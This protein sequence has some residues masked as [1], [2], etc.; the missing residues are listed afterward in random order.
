[1]MLEE[2]FRRDRIVI[3]A[4]LRKA[5]ATE[6]GVPRRLAQAMGYALL[7]GGKR[8]RPFLALEG[9]RAAGGR[10]SGRVLRFC[11][12]LEMVHAFSLVHDDLPSMDNA[13]VRRGRASLHRRFDEATAILAADALLARGFGLMAESPGPR[14]RVCRVISLVA[15][16]IGAAG[17][18][19]GQWEDMRP[20]RMTLARLAAVQR[21]KTGELIAASL[22]GGAI[23]AGA[24]HDVERALWQAGLAVGA[25]FQMTDDLLD[26]AE[27]GERKGSTMVG[28]LGRERTLRRARAAAGRAR[29]LLTGLG[30]RF[31]LLAEVP[32][33]VLERKD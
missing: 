23:L 24:G 7:G 17:M 11:C 3:D 8:I 16:A 4:A 32:G 27:G 31:A 28:R 9:F 30:P 25:C 33:Y 2:A 26:A 22:A 6:R 15:R 18:T 21:R 1:M 10:Q 19:G 13:D 5:L 12:G 20:G 29:A 14:V